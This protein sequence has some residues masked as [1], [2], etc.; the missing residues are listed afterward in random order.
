MIRPSETL[1]G[2]NLNSVWLEG[3]LVAE[4]EGS[5]GPG[6]GCVF[7]FQVRDHR[8]QDPGPA[9]V[10]AVEAADSAL[11][12]CRSRLGAGHQVRIIGRLKQVRREVSIVGE[13]VE[14]L[15]P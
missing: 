8:P 15:G 6:G 4:P 12:G 1:L 10:F 7:R 9:S 5:V 2:T 11:E 13:L 3:T 14:A